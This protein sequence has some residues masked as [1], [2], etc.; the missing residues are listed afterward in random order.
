M[1]A[2]IMPLIFGLIL[3]MG[4]ESA[5][6]QDMQ[7]MLELIPPGIADRFAGMDEQQAALTYALLYFFAPLYLL[8]PVMVSNVVAAD[9]FAG[10]KERKTLEAL[11][12]TPTSDRE[13]LWAKLLAAWIPGVV[14]G[15]LSFVAY[16]IVVDIVA[17]PVVGHLLLPN[18]LW[19][20]IALWVGPAAA[21]LGL[22]AAVLVSSRGLSFS[23]TCRFPSRLARIGC[24][25]PTR[26]IG[27]R[28]LARQPFGAQTLAAPMW[29][30]SGLQTCPAPPRRLMGQASTRRMMSEAF[31]PPNPNELVRIVLISR[32][33]AV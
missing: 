33:R 1:I 4:G 19:L 6:S 3:R 15:L 2:V 32:L 14:V 5:T 7:S 16:C 17:W 11:L 18:L 28:V 25:S 20:I 31:V 27:F 12:Y 29:Q 23:L 30:K 22:G 13:L 9:S 21:A 26:S 24:A 10:E 8:L